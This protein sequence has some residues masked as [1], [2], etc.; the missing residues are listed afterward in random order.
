MSTIFQDLAVQALTA[1]IM[2]MVL[3]FLDVYKSC[4]KGRNSKGARFANFQ[5]RW[6]EHIHDYLE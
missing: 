4:M 3:A 6:L 1:C 2:G 5:Q